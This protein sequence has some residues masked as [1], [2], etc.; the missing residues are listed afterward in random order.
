[1][2]PLRYPAPFE[3]A[4]SIDLVPALEVNSSQPLL[5]LQVTKAPTTKQAGWSTFVPPYCKVG[6]AQTA[7]AKVRT[8]S[9]IDFAI[10][11][12]VS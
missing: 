7:V 9:E 6:S 4:R 2:C 5:A 1:M 11:V 10:S 8:D 12:K 3:S